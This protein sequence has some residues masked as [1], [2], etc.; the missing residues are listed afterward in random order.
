VIVDWYG[1]DAH[2]LPQ[3]SGQNRLIFVL[4]SHKAIASFLPQEKR[5]PISAK[6]IALVRKNLQQDRISPAPRK[7]IAYFGK[8]R[9][10]LLFGNEF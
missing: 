7:A 2:S 6:Q 4:M 9:C 8:I 1:F 5:S 10:D 3:K